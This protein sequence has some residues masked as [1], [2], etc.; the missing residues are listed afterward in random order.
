MHVQLHPGADGRCAV[1]FTF[2]QVLVPAGIEP[3]ST[4]TRPLGA[5]FLNFTY[6]P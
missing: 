1:A 6:K 4:D 5:H 3:G 2:D